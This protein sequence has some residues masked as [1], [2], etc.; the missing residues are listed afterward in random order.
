MLNEYTATLRGLMLKYKQ[1]PIVL[2]IC[3]IPLVLS[4]LWLVLSGLNGA[5]EGHALADTAP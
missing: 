4:G 2:C 3:K 5:S 1:N